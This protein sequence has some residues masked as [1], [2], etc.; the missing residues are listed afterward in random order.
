MLP[1]NQENI[2]AIATPP[3]VGALAVVRIS[4]GNLKQLYKDFTHKTPK[5][6]FASFSRLYHPQKNTILDEAVVTYFKSPNSFTGEDV[7]EI[8]CHGGEAVKNSI[9]SAALDC[10]VRLAGPGEFSF[11]SFLNGKIDL[12]QAEAVSAL[13]SSKTSLSSE[14]SLHHLG[15]KVSTLLRDIK[16]KIITILSIIENELNFS[17]NEIDF[18]SY[19][20]LKSKIITV[21]SQ[22]KQLLDSS[23]IGKNIFSGIRIIIYGKPNSGKSSL[24]NAILG[25]DR[26]IT[27]SIPGTTRDTVEAW[28][29]LEGIPVCLIDTAGIWE[30]EK[31]LDNLGV[32]K[33]L[34]ELKHADICLLVDEKDPSSLLD[35]AFNKKF[36]HHY[37][38]V[39]TKL[40]LDR[41]PLIK[42]NNTIATSSINNIGIKKL[43]TSLSTYI[44]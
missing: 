25:H 21:K 34:S 30:P 38:M 14:I 13:I 44:S 26:A 27:S 16:T 8:S 9:V 12:I 17:E 11:R 19:S 41:S 33:T 1:Y 20:E 18:T 43:L 28:F 35:P 4:G 24:F 22:I 23:V 42:R 6:R 31:H 36:K 3:G 15:G 32:E 40:D 5:N 7:I 29:E 39:K 10:G 37:I 2:V